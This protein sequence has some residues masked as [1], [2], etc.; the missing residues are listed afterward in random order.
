MLYKVHWE[1]FDS[2]HDS[3][4][5]AESLAGCEKLIQRYTKE[6]SSAELEVSINTIVINPKLFFLLRFP[7]ELEG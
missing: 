5:P 4:E 7:R 3:W 6:S 1:G 2:N